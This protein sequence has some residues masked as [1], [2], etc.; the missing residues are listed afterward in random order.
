VAASGCAFANSDDGSGYGFYTNIYTDCGSGRMPNGNIFGKLQSSTTLTG[1][2]AP[3]F[4]DVNVLNWLDA[5][6]DGDGTPDNLDDEDY[7]G[8][9]NIEEIT[10]G[11]DTFLS[12]PKDPCDPNPDSRSCPTHG[13]H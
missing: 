12:A 9:S 11:T 7:D 13:S 3:A 2:P 5:D 6:S 1:G 10:A 8:V 4:T